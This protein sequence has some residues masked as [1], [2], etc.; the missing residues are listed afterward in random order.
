MVIRISSSSI[1]IFSIC[2]NFKGTIEGRRVT[3]KYKL[4][5][6]FKIDVDNDYN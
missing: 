3:I 2:T 1:L 6:G 5:C 4:L